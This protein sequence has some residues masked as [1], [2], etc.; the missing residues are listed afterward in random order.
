LKNSREERGAEPD[1]C[2][3]ID[4]VPESDDDRPDIAVEVVWTSG[5]IDK[6]GVCRKLR[7]FPARTPRSSYAAWPNLAR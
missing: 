2:Y 7:S 5:G 1:E 3:M 4:R 6:F